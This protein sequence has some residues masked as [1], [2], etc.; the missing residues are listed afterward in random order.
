MFCKKCGKFIDY[1]SD[2]CNECRENNTT[3]SASTVIANEG[4][5]TKEPVGRRTYGLGL[6]IAGAAIGLF[7]AIFS[8]LAYVFSLV[9]SVVQTEDYYQMGLTLADLDALGILS[10]I[11]AVFGIILAIPAI[12]FGAVSIKRFF[13]KKKIG[14][15]KPIPT[16]I[17]G[18]V[19]VGETAT[20]ILFALISVLIML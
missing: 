9:V 5:A 17:I 15:K 7:S 19:T 11:C 13:Q 18:I 16:L 12:I 10:Y 2:V 8:C 3:E 6:A 1:D 14:E 4:E 20:M